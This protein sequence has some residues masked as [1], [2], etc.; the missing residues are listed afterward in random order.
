MSVHSTYKQTKDLRHTQE[1]LN[2][3]N[4]FQIKGESSMRSNSGRCKFDIR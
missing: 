2:R 3:K 1:I 4:Q